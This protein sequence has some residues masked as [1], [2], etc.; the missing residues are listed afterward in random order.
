MKFK[1]SP[2]VGLCSTTYGDDICRGCYR[3]RHEVVEWNRLTDE[4]KNLIVERIKTWKEKNLA[5]VKST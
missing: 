2:C 4:Q 1:R 5:S 3:T